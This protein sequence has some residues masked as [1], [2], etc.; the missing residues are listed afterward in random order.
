MAQAAAIRTP[1][2]AKGRR[3]PGRL[4][5]RRHIE[6]AT[7]KVPK[8]ASAQTSPEVRAI[9]A[10]AH[11]FGYVDARG[12][13]YDD[14][15]ER[16]VQL[17]ARLSGS[18]LF[19]AAEQHIENV[20]LA[21]GS[22]LK[23][24]LNQEGAWDGESFEWRPAAQSS[25]LELRKSGGGALPGVAKRRVALGSA[26]R[27][28][29]GD[30]L[31]FQTIVF[32]DI[33]NG[34]ADYV[35]PLL[36]GRGTRC[37]ASAP[38]HV[39]TMVDVAEFGTPR[40]KSIAL[41][42]RRAR[43]AAERCGDQEK[44][45]ELLLSVQNLGYEQE[46]TEEEGEDEDEE[47][48]EEEE[49][50]DGAGEWL[51]R[52]SDYFAGQCSVSY[53]ASEICAPGDAPFA[54]EVVRLPLRVLPR[55]SAVRSVIRPRFRHA[56]TVVCLHNFNTL[57]PWDCYEHL[58]ALPRGSPS[59]GFVRVV[60]VL[61]DDGR[62][63]DYP[64]LGAY[65]SGTPWLDVIDPSSMV[66]TDVLLEK[67]VDAEIKYVGDSR[68]VVLFGKS[69]GGGQAL[70]RLM[71]SRQKLGG[72]ISAMS[73]VPTMPHIPCFADPLTGGSPQQGPFVNS[74]TPVRMLHGDIDQI[75]SPTMVLKGAQRL[76]KLGGFTDVEVEV[77]EG[78]D[79][80]NLFKKD[81]LFADPDGPPP[82]LTFL[83]KHLPGM[84]AQ[85]R[86]VKRVSGGTKAKRP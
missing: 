3:K 85:L 74:S 31:G 33:S 81:G 5:V 86:P 48:E 18:I 34:A 41:A 79:H 83:R 75:F 80:E 26:R 11:Q 4:R 14:K 20:C 44:A 43:K 24:A 1:T 17:L 39:Y 6:K 49:A 47:E 19:V 69:Q 77:K 2:A 23:I 51:P 64:D 65:Q 37:Q 10:S 36:Q 53:H 70:F 46:Q 76:C 9:L 67:L 27:L 54:V 25:F 57:G 60:M 55:L 71:R 59:S 58:F 72:C 29:A 12:E 52:I 45:T 62:Y 78:L 40:C 63:H 8:R 13:D 22:A 84:V 21:L 50:D 42:L 66:E 32:Y 7:R 16:A 35:R 61:A 28:A 68:R 38:S 30:A 56:C 15:R 82:E 73:H